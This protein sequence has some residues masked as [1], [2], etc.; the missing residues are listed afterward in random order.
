MRP[1]GLLWLKFSSIPFLVQLLFVMKSLIGSK[2][3]EPPSLSFSLFSSCCFAAACCCCCSPAAVRFQKPSLPVAA[4]SLRLAP[5]QKPRRRSACVAEHPPA[6]QHLLHCSPLPTHYPAGLRPPSPHPF[7][8]S[9]LQWR[10]AANP[11][12]C[13][14]SRTIFSPEALATCCANAKACRIRPRW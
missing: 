9:S 13:T 6:P 2:R 5:L 4:R 7:F 10:A 3:T 1:D 8:I 14:K 11:I 12:P